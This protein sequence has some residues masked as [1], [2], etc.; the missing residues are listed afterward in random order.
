MAFSN[1]KTITYV[2]SAKGNKL[3]AVHGTDTTDYAGNRIYKNGRLD[4]VLTDNGYITFAGSAPAYHYY[5]TDHQGNNR[6][7]INAA[8]AAEQVN[9]YYPFGGLLAESTGG[10]TQPWLYG[11]KELDASD[12]L[13]VYDYGARFYDPVLGA[14]LQSD[15]KADRHYSVSPYVYCL[16][17]PVKYADPDG[18]LPVI[19]LPLIKGAVGAAIDAGAQVTAHMISGKSFGEA[20]SNIDYTS[21]GAAFI[22]SAVS[23]SGL[24]TA[25]KSAVTTATITTDVIVDITPQNGIKNIGNGKSFT[26]A[27]VDAAAAV[28]PGMS[29]DKLTKSFTEAITTDLTA[30]SAATM[31]KAAKA[32]LKRTRS[33]VNGKKFQDAANGAAD[34]AGGTLGTVFN[35][36]VGKKEEASSEENKDKKRKRN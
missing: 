17:S 13:N 27:G 20:V 11:G 14:W 21:V 16:N 28:L 25:L 2:Y 24:S 31:T 19:L 34:Y 12:G 5:L 23:V 32:E 26:Q 10:D 29:V 8:G 9:H 3:R 35:N 30:N 18:K 6:L 15:P 36:E 7:V 22:V 4:K 33:V 1:G